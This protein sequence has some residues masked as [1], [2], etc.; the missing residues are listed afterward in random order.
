MVLGELPVLGRLTS[1]ARA[2]CACSRCGWGMFGHFFFRLSFFFP[3][4]D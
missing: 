4:I 1:T 2:Y 3:D